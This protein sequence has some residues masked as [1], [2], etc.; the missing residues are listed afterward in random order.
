M[1]DF[2][3]ATVGDL[4]GIHEVWWAADPFHA[5]NHNP[6]FRH[7]LRTGSMLVATLAGRVVGF[8]GVREVGDTKVCRIA[9]SNPSI[10]PGGSAPAFWH[11]Y[12]RSKDQS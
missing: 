6:W 11:G 4:A 7:V 9:S 2:R 12:Y 8:A 1:I 10:K 5:P 3:S